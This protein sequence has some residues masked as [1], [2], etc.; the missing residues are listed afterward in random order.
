MRILLTGASG[1]IGS[2]LKAFVQQR[3]H[4]VTAL[5]RLGPDQSALPPYWDPDRPVIELGAGL[6]A[7]AV[8]HLAGESLA[9]RWSAEKKRRIRHS[10]VQ[11][12]QLLCEAL[13]QQPVRPRV[14]VCAS[15]IG[16]YGD[17]AATCLDEQSP[18][19]TGFLAEVCQA[20]EAA[21]RPASEAGIRVV[22]LRVGLVLSAQGGALARMLPAFRLGLGGRI[23]SGRQ[24]WSW[25]ALDDLLSAI[26]HVLSREDLTGPVN[27]VAPAP[28][29]QTEFAATLARVLRRPA[30]TPLPAWLARL[31]LGQ[32]AQETL[33]ASARVR[34][35]RLLETGFTFGYPA[36]EPALR[37]LLS[38]PA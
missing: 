32:M 2:A 14:L 18:P 24:F 34:P 19:G 13:G 4:A 22:R 1:F 36:L 27:A 12:T 26:L 15:A 35:G 28:V 11:G 33:L 30:L 29:T 20:W 3:G 8:V 25:I 10:R 38:K 17:Q 9:G 6:A 31:L 21:T 7:E 23:G 5:R 37:H 16:F